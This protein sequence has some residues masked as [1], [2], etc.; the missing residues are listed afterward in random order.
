MESF[1]DSGKQNEVSTNKAIYSAGTNVYLRAL[2]AQPCGQRVKGESESKATQV[3]MKT[4]S[5]FTQTVYYYVKAI[6][7]TSPVGMFSPCSTGPRLYECSCQYT[8]SIGRSSSQ[9]TT[10]YYGSTGSVHITAFYIRK[11]VGPL[12]SLVDPCIALFSFLR[13]FY[14][15]SLCT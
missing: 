1:W 4:F 14:K 11:Q 5:H 9:H 15:N 8:E 10:L 13:L 7:G 12:W 2:T 6:N 3:W